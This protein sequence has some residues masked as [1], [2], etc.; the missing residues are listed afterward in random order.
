M[1]VEPTKLV[2]I[3]EALELDPSGIASQIYCRHELIQQMVG[4]LYRDIL[5]RQIG[6]LQDKL[7][8]LRRKDAGL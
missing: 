5:W 2:D 4:N 7:S 8:E 3:T 6:Q 1:C